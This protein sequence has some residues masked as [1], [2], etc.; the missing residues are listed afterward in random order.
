MQFR[1]QRMEGIFIDDRDGNA[2]V[3][4]KFL[5]QLLCGQNACISRTNN[6]NFCMQT[7]LLG[8]NPKIFSILSD[9][10]WIVNRFGDL[11]T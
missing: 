6:D 9:N 2:F 11:V 5:F 8:F 3:F 1:Q 10:R 7:V 4:A